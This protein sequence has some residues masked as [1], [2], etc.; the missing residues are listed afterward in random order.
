MYAVAFA[1]SAFTET[2][3]FSAADLQL[4]NKLRL[5]SARARCAPRIDAFTTCSLL[6]GLPMGSA[7]SY[8]EALLRLSAQNFD[9][10]PVLYHPGSSDLSR[11]EA[12]LLRLIISARDEDEDSLQFM[13]RRWLS[14]DLARP[15]LFL[16][17][18][19]ARRLESL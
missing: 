5:L 1:P 13:A 11:D 7:A 8:A 19:L 16:C 17:R 6:G 3:P 18:N 14:R 2:A 12:V 10:P 4:L 9:R 15:I